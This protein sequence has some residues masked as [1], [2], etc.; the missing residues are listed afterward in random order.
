MRQLLDEADRVADQD[1]RLGLRL[2]R[3]HGGVERGEELVGDQHVAAGQRAHQRR[4]AGVGVADE[5]DRRL[6]GAPAAARGGVLLDRRELAAQLGDAVAHLAPVELERRLAGALAADAAAL[7]VLAAAALAQARRQVVEA[8][9]L[10]LQPRLA[11]AGVALEDR[12]DD[13]RAVEHLGA[14]G[15]LEVARLRRARCRGRRAR[16]WPRSA[17]LRRLSSSPSSRLG[18]G[19]VAR[20]GAP[21]RPERHHAA[22]AGQAGQLLEL[23]LADHRGGGERRG[24]SGS[25]GRPPRARASWPGARAR[26]ATRRAPRRSRRAAARRRARREPAVLATSRGA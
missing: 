4:L 2:Q 11:A 23:A 9:D 5:R 21:A 1:A 14:G 20:C 8:R 12:E 3:A 19:S 18:V 16:R 17:A 13:R 15:A 26:P 6:R 24:A 10:H 25:R 22:A 7:A